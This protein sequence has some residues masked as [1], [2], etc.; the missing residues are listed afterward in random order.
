MQP[1]RLGLGLAEAEC[2]CGTL[3]LA[4]VSTSRSSFVAS[5]VSIRW[6]KLLGAA[7]WG[8][9]RLQRSSCAFGLAVAVRGL[10]RPGAATFPEAMFYVFMAVVLLSLSSLFLAQIPKGKACEVEVEMETPA[11][12][13][14]CRTADRPRRSVSSNFIDKVALE[15]QR[16]EHAARPQP[17]PRLPRTGL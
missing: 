6:S 12:T 5:I 17:L 2:L 7:F 8:S 11:V 14:C 4:L 10:V 16:R 15:A 3:E 1:N 9:V 13:G